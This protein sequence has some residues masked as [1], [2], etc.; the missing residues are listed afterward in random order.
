MQM[1]HF[2]LIH[3]LF[4]KMQPHLNSVIHL[5]KEKENFWL[6]SLM[7]FCNHC[8]MSKLSITIIY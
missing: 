7:R 2:I 4:T 5:E 8:H 1:I 3:T 6:L